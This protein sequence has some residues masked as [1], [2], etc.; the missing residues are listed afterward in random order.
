ML[1]GDTLPSMHSSFPLINLSQIR[2]KQGKAKPERKGTL[3]AIYRA[4]GC[5]SRMKGCQAANS[6]LD[7]K[8]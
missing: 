4:I 6:F 8:N 1:R 2:E 3:L 5:A 7:T